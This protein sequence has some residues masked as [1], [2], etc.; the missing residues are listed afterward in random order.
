LIVAPA[1]WP[2]IETVPTSTEKNCHEGTFT[3]TPTTM[4]GTEDKRTIV[5]H[6]QQQQL[7]ATGERI[8]NN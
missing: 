5:E 6:D 3:R 7:T 8:N 2:T 4:D 1:V